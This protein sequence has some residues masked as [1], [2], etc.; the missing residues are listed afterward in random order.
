MIAAVVFDLGGVL[1][2]GEGIISEP[3]RLLGVDPEEFERLYW[4]HRRAYD[5]G[6]SDADY[7]RP[8]LEGLGKPAAVE[9]IQ[10][11]AALDAGLWLRLRPE[12]RAILHDVH[13]TGLP[14]AVLSNAPFS[15]DQGL[16]DVDFADEAD[17]WF[18][19]AS[20]GMSKPN[21]GVYERVTEVL[22]V[23]PDS[24]AFV[25][26]RRDNVAGAERAGWQTHL[27]V[28]DADTRA[29]LT[30]LGVLAA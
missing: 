23:A 26:D 6:C 25:D 13:E 8:I 21:R 16:L 4:A 29:W 17:Y 18:M 24:I 10:Q 27:W 1:A 11:L 19:S 15:V 2:S 5:D 28:S 9:T 22:D 7:W 14:V 12:A 30:D 3:S 20:M